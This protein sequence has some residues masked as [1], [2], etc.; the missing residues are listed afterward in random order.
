MEILKVGTPR[1]R[2][3]RIMISSVLNVLLDS[4]C[5]SVPNSTSCCKNIAAVVKL[6]SIILIM[7]HFSTSDQV[8]DAAI[9]VGVKHI[10]LPEFTGDF[11]TP[12]GQDLVVFN[13]KRAAREYAVQKAKE[14]KITWS[15]VTTGAFIDLGKYS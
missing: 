9:I 1:A 10:V 11:M 5:P 6:F 7:I 14:G 12:R 8:I 4:L 3:M 15:A 2:A 13:Y